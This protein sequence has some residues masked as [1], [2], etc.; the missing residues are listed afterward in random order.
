MENR[1]TMLPATSGF[2]DVSNSASSGYVQHRREAE[3]VSVRQAS[4]HVFR[5]PAVVTNRRPGVVPVHEDRRL[6]G[7]PHSGRHSDGEVQLP[8]QPM[9]SDQR[10]SLPRGTRSAPGCLHRKRRTNDVPKRDV[11]GGLCLHHQQ[12]GAGSVR[13]ANKGRGPPQQPLR[14]PSAGLQV[15]VR[16]EAVEQASRTCQRATYCG[17]TACPRR[18]RMTILIQAVDT[19]SPTRFL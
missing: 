14:Q 19:N 18:A 10:L 7:R 16:R 15:E 2:G 11:H 13:P 4:K 3:R 9:Q 1:S 12:N 5:R 8:R 17:T 6:A